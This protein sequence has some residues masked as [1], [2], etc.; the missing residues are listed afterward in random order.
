[1]VMALKA[2]ERKSNGPKGE[3]RALRKEGHVP[4]VVYGG[5]DAPQSISIALK[6]I[7]KEIGRPSFFNHIIELECAGKKGRVLPRDVHY[8]PVTDLPLHIDFMRVT[9]DALVT[10]AVPLKF[11]NAD[12]SPGIKRGALLNIV[13]QAIEISLSP[14]SIP[15]HIVIDLE[16][17]QMGEAIHLDSLNLP[18]EWRIIHAERD[19]TLA[20]IVAPSGLSDE[21]KPDSAAS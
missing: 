15:E 7:I 16:G 3:V 14:D 12:K 4:A 10:V 5:T 1:M 9:K 20:T 11:I 6:D 18:Q 19:N 8:H 2:E 13:V 21:E 17:R